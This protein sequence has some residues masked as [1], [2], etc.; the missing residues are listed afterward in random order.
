MPGFIL[1]KGGCCHAARSNHRRAPLRPL[2]A[3]RDG[4]LCAVAVLLRLGLGAAAAAGGT[5]PQ[6]AV[7]QPRSRLGDR[8]HPLARAHPAGRQALCRRQCAGRRARLSALGR[9]GAAARPCGAV[10]AEPGAE[11]RPRLLAGRTVCAVGRL[12]LQQPF[13]SAPAFPARCGT[14]AG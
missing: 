12:P 7:C 8:L 4:A 9:G 11:Q 5:F 14:Q 1:K 13:P 3:R 6:P 10:C 2:G